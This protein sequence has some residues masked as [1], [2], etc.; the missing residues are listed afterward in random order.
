MGNVTPKRINGGLEIMRNQAESIQNSAPG[1]IP[2]APWRVTE[3]QPLIGHRLFVRFIDGTTGEVD[4]S[5]L[6]ISDS[7]GVFVALRDPMLFE[8]AY[9]EYGVV[10]WPGEID[11]A[12]DAMYD[13]IKKHGRWVPE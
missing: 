10:M 6:V 7:A 3:V 5:R 13:E 2:C 4:L 9:I 1:I 11:L 12:P 8:K